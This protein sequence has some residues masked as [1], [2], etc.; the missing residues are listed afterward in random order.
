MKTSIDEG[1]EVDYPDTGSSDSSHT[2]W[3]SDSQTSSVGRLSSSGSGNLQIAEECI[4][5]NGHF[6]I[7]CKFFAWTE[8]FFLINTLNFEMSYSIESSLRSLSTF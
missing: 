8:Y 6:V 1:V 7:I 2:H 4:K 3:T 5:K